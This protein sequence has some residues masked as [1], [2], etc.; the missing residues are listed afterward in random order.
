MFP[1][2]LFVA[3]ECGGVRTE[4]GTVELSGSSGAQIANSS[5][6]LVCTCV[7]GCDS[8]LRVGVY[9]T[10]AGAIRVGNSSTSHKACPVR[11]LAR[12]GGLLA[13]YTHL[14]Q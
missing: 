9:V 3:A 13:L 5:V 11:G 7:R 6:H 4:R 2:S 14:P 8:R 1:D 10:A 12:L